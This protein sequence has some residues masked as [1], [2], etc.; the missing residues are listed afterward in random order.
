MM[1]QPNETNSIYVPFFELIHDI[2]FGEH[3]DAHHFNTNTL[4]WSLTRLFGCYERVMTVLHLPRCERPYLDADVE[5]FLIRY[6][7]VLNDI[8]FIVRQLFPTNTRGLRSA[9][10]RSHPTNREMSVFDLASY[11]ESNPA[12]HPELS[13]AFSTAKQ[14]MTL[15]KNVRDN[16]IHYK[17][18]AVIFEGAVPEIAFLSAS[19]TERTISTKGG[20]ERLVVEPVSQV[21]NLPMLNLHNFMHVDLTT[22][23]R[24]HAVRIGMIEIKCGGDERIICRGIQTF[25][26]VN[27]IH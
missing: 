17:A 7:I 12:S 25:R 26:S 18:K 8:A 23:I 1:P 21:V 16:V 9:K 15:M 3:D 11:F 24:A 19:G 14:W 13:A 10:G 22:A 6:R 5:S 20:G 4:F 27:N 2:G